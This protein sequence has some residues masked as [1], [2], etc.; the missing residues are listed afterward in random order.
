M[1]VPYRVSFGSQL[2]MPNSLCLWEEKGTGGCKDVDTGKEEEDSTFAKRLDHV[3]G[4]P[5][6]DQVPEPLG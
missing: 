1:V 5:G 4:E 3:G 2:D 6:D